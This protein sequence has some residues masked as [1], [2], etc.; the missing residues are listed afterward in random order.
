MELKVIDKFRHPTTGEMIKIVQLKESGKFEGQ[1]CAFNGFQIKT[2]TEIL[3]LEE[4][5]DWFNTLKEKPEIL[6]MRQTVLFTEFMKGY[7]PFNDLLDSFEKM[8]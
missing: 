2:K 5:T 6:E 3:T 8:K 7:K 4:V 1:L